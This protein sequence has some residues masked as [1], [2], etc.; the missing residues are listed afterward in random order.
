M[1]I[2]CLI[3]D[4]ILWLFWGPFREVISLLPIK[5]VYR[6]GVAAGRLRK[7]IGKKRRERTL[8][9]IIATPAFSGIDTKAAVDRA[10]QVSFLNEIETFFYPRFN[11]KNIGAFTGIT[12][13]EYLKDALNAGKGVMLVHAHF[14]KSSDAHVWPWT[15]G[16]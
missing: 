14:G 6:I 13:E 2:K 1:M 15:Q 3:R 16:I 11:N 10:F 9:E 8:N 5:T 4:S 12:G 7:I